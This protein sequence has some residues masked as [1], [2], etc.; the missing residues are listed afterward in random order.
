[1]PMLLPPTIF[2]AEHIYPVWSFIEK[3]IALL[4]Q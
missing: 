3:K 2:I 1:M 4:D